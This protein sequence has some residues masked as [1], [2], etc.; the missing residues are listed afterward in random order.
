MNR[1]GAI[2]RCLVAAALA[3]AATAAPA[4]AQ[5]TFRLFV[6]RV[7]E[8]RARTA[9]NDTSGRLTLM[10]RLEGEGLKDA[11]AFRV[12]LAEARDATGR[13]L[14]PDEPEPTI[15]EEN[16]AGPG[17]W[18]ALASP[19]R[20][21]ESV[22]VSGTVELWAPDRDPGAEVTL[23]KGLARPGK[24][25]AAKGLRDAGVA[26]ALAPRDAD[27]DVVALTGRAAD[28]ARVRSVRV[29]DADGGEVASNG[30]QRS[31]DGEKATLEL[32]LSAPPAPDATL[33]VGLLTKKSV[34]S[35]PFELKDV[36]L[37]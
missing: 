20:E 1:K 10:P 26:L 24:P 25:L 14:L 15:W 9:S 4:R 34:V 37:P 22:T 19:A 5:A 35:V 36:P 11:K 27:S 21:A 7:T 28:V 3:W 32:L 16:P 31:S 12:L 33:V 8:S 23:P 2:Q 30:V 6:D 18:I 13:S 17:L 29:L